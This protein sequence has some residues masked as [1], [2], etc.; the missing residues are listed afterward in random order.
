MDKK[1]AGSD[2]L[3]KIAKQHNLKLLVLYNYNLS[4]EPKSKA[5]RFVYVLKGR[6][7]E[8]GIVERLGGKF[9][10]PGCF[11]IPVKSDKEMQSVFKLW[12]IKLKRKLLL[13]D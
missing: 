12:N 2:I 11:T 10:A 5:V 13:T 7:D 4:K 9:L 3:N 1:E 8:P 6:G